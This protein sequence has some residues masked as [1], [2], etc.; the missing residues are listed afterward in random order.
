MRIALASHFFH[1]SV[2]GTEEVAQVLAGEFVKQGHQVRILTTTAL[3][4]GVAETP[5]PFEVL[6]QPTP[7]ELWR[8]LNWAEVVL[9]NNLCLRMAWPLLFLRKPWVVSHHIWTRRMD[10]R[11]ALQD[12]LK[13]L[14]IRSARNVAVSAAIGRDLPVPAE[15]IGNPYRDG[16]YRQ[17]EGVQRSKTLLFVGRLTEGKGLDL[18]LS[19]LQLLQGRGI[20]IP[21]TVVGDGPDRPKLEALA[22]QLLGEPAPIEFVGRQRP[23]ELA[24]IYNEHQF[25]VIPSMWNEPFGLVAL[26]AIACGCQPIGAEDG[27]L[28]EAIG[29]CGQIFPRANA[30]ALAELLA[31]GPRPVPDFQ[32]KAQLHIARFKAERVASAYLEVMEAAINQGATR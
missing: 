8:V 32:S 16:I 17:I 21:L 27:G 25:L 4:T 12:R 2:G 9:H 11:R 19:A 10:G 24:R 7:R 23:E 28:P 31:A 3:S 20:Q 18:L 5:F 29:P 15:I 1:P 30:E 13:L 14:A 6:R 26:E 22:R